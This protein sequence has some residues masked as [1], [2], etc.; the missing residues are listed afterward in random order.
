VLQEINRARTDPAHYTLLSFGFPAAAT[1]VGRSFLRAEPPIAP[2]EW[3][4]GLSEAA[5][6]QA[7]DQGPEGQDSHVGTDG[8]RPMQR[9]QKAGVW[10]MMEDEVI[11]VGE[12]QPA[13]VVAQLIIDPPDALHLHRSVLF[14]PMMKSAGVACGPNARFGVMCVIDFAGAPVPRD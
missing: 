11:S 7:A 3:G 9:M 2:L 4:D 12:N 5:G 8:S 14:D 1:E 13:G 10:S 6:V